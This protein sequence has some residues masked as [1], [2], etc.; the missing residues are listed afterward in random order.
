MPQTPPPTIV[1]HGMIK[2]GA[3]VFL[4]PGWVLAIAILL[5]GYAD[6]GDGF[7]AGVIAAVIVILQGIAFG[8]EELEHIRV[9]RFAPVMCF[10]GL[11]LAYAVAFVPT[12]FGYSILTHF[13]RMNE[14]AAHFGPLEFITPVLFDIAVFLVVYGFCVGAVMTVARAELRHKRLLQRARK[15]GGNR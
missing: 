10:I 12:F 8:A 13:P 3:R 5:K 4:V 9:A 6:I 7:A 14:H 11:A 15:R 2:T 1:P